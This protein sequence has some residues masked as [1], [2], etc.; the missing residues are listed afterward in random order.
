MTVIKMRNAIIKTADNMSDETYKMLCDGIKQKFGE[1][2][3]CTRKIDN[4]VIGG[5]TL[6]LDGVI[7]D[8]SIKTQLKRL[9]KHISN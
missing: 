8:N 5:F 4:S 7:Y 9:K 6:S 2:V 1:D 3:E